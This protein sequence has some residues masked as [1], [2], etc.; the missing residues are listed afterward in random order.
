MRT[1]LRPQVF[2][3]RIDSDA[4]HALDETDPNQQGVERLD[5]KTTLLTS[6]SNGALREPRPA[7][8]HERA[9]QSSNRSWAYTG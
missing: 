4:K 8:G 5:C 1:L 6:A 3:A 2:P 7:A 9:R